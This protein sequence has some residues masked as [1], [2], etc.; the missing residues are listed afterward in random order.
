MGYLLFGAVEPG[1][2]NIYI[3]YDYHCVMMRGGKRF[4]ESSSVLGKATRG[5]PI[6]DPNFW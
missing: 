3:V 4:L 5:G 6:Y 2:L 1:V